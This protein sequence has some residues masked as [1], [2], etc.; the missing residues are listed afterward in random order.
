M[1]V[2]GAIW[3]SDGGGDGGPTAVDPNPDAVTDVGS[4]DE[5]GASQGNL[6]DAFLSYAGE[7][8]LDTGEFEQCLGDQGRAEVIGNH[9]Q[10]GDEL[11]VT[12]TPTFF[13]NNK[14]IVGA[15]P[16]EIFLEIIEQE[17][18]GSP[19]STDAYSEA[20]Q[21]LAGTS[22]PRFEIVDTVPDVS[23][24]PIE[25]NP[26]AGV[27]IAEFS[28]FQCP[29]CQRWTQQS[30]DAI[31]AELGEDVAL[32]FMHFPLTQ[33][34]PNAGNASYAAVCAGEQDAFW[35]M[36]DLLFARQSQWADLRRSMTAAESP[37]APGARRRDAVLAARSALRCL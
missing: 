19:T 37:E 4:G 34:H 26:D 14:K 9:L 31:R 16:T 33:L 32:A 23:N 10:Q 36:H 28:D 15:Q 29:F 27:M 22:P 8:D 18:E 1:L 20:I 3:L 25:G 7:L 11:G 17:R 6:L 24:A 21:Q 2:A 35:E 5:G 30:M 13:I 12:G